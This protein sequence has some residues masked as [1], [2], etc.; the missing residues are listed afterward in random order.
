ML[1]GQAMARD[2]ALVMQQGQRLH[3]ACASKQL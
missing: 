2:E 1:C 3:S